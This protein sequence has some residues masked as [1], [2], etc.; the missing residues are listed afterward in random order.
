MR[1]EKDKY[2]PSCLQFPVPKTFKI[3]ITGEI[4][5]QL[6]GS[7]TVASTGKTITS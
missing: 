6:F 4:A 7:T 5:P 1:H 3:V 2:P